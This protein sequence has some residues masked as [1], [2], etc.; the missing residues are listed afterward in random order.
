[1]PLIFDTVDYVNDAG[2][3]YSI[4]KLEYYL[5]FIQLEREDGKIYLA[6][7]IFYVNAKRK[8]Q[9]ITLTEIPSGHYTRISFLIGINKAKNKT[10][11]LPAT[12]ENLGMA[13]PD[14]MGGGY[15][16]IKM[17]GHFSDTQN[18]KQGYAIHLGTDAMQVAHH[19]LVYNVSVSSATQAALHLN[20]N[21]N[22]WLRNPHTYDFMKDGNYTMSDPKLMKLINENGKDVYTL[23]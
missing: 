6:D 4:S 1:M 12:T 10:D 23:R 16:F 11:Y 5:S 20:M 14:M 15:H 3:K 17:E 13:W 19:P 18:N 9:H 7:S 2:Y 8:N 21:V 22:E